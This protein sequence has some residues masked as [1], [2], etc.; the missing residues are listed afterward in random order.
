MLYRIIEVEARP[1]F[2]VWIRFE[3]GT[4]GE[5]DLSDLVGNGVFE[6]LSDPEEFERVYIDEET[7]TLAWPGELDVAPDRLY[8]DLKPVSTSRVRER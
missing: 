2:R 3:D 5:V 8:R 7:G 6:P 1:D 4:Q